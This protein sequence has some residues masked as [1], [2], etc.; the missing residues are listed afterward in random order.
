M[1]AVIGLVLVLIA[2]IA[3]ILGL[4]GRLTAEQEHLDPAT[5]ATLE[6]EGMV[7][8]DH[9]FNELVGEFVDD[10][11]DRSAHNIVT[12]GSNDRTALPEDDPAAATR[13]QRTAMTPSSGTTD[14]SGPFDEP[15]DR[16]PRTH[17]NG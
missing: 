17:P 14:P 8:P 5:V 7:N 2:A 9:A 10:P 1:L 12:P 11:E 4:I 16:A 6:D 15:G 13:E 3:A